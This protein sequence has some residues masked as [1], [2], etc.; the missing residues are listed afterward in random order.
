MQKVGSKPIK[1]YKRK[2][3]PTV[4]QQ[5]GEEEKLSQKS[6]PLKAD[7]APVMA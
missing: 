2:R 6:G 4:P 7:G 1:S 5:P 3:Q